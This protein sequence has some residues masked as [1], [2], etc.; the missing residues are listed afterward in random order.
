MADV[1]LRDAG[2][3][4]MASHSRASVEIVE[5]LARLVVSGTEILIPEIAD[6]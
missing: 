1:V 3:L 4:G 6:Y 2:P 5:W